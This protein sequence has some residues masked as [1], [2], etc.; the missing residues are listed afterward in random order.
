MVLEYKQEWKYEDTSKLFASK[1][2]KRNNRFPISYKWLITQYIILA[3]RPYPCK[4]AKLPSSIFK[5]SGRFSKNKT[6][7]FWPCWNSYSSC[8][9]SMT[10]LGNKSSGSVFSTFKQTN[11][12]LKPNKQKTYTHTL[13]FIYTPKKWRQSKNVVTTSQA[14][15][16]FLAIS[17]G[18]VLDLYLK[19]KFPGQIWYQE[20]GWISG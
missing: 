6:W 11:K 14:P 17:L 8:P 13:G 4:I 2:R 3:N 7:K 18:C 5:N 16:C 10:H 20:R 15:Y 1:N 9:Q 12:K 19:M